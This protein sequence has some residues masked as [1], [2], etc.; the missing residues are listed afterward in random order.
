MS[1]Q[2]YDETTLGSLVLNV[3]TQQQ[4]DDIQE[5]N[6]DELYLIKDVPEDKGIYYIEGNVN[7][8]AGQW[9]GTHNSIK[10]YYP[11]LVIAYKIG[12]K[13][14]STATELEIN[15]LGKIPVVKNQ[16]TNISTTYGVNSVVILIYTVDKGEGYW[17][18][19]D[20]STNFVTQ[21]YTKN[22]SIYPLLFKYDAGTTN[23][24]D[25][26]TSTQYSNSIYVNPSSGTIT[27]A[28]FN[29]PAT[30]ATNDSQG[31][32]ITE[33]Y[34]KQTNPTGTGTFAL[35]GNKAIGTNS[36]A[37]GK[38]TT[39][40]GD[41]SHAEGT[42]INFPPDNIMDETKENIYSN[43][44]EQ[45]EL[46]G[47]YSLAYGVGS[48]V[49]G[50]NCLALGDQSHAEGGRTVAFEECSHAE[51]FAVEAKG[52]YSHAEGIS[53]IATAEGSHVE[54]R[55]NIIDNDKKYL[56]IV[57]NGTDVKKSNAF[58]LDQ[59][60]NAWFAGDIYIGSASGTNKDDGSKKVATEEFVLSSIG[61]NE[62]LATKQYVDNLIGA[63]LDGAS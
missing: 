40:K 45:G 33:T 21:K 22:N 34:M 10:E 7:G 38:Q 48:H 57:G 25:T 60:G 24:G 27:A 26:T 12:T 3:L 52:R 4:F 47:L 1:S 49:E 18:T 6:A 31:N 32:V 28:S 2:K 36:H 54:G 42:S 46:N 11:G 58:T 41:Y 39:A 20:Y 29:G 43:W 53:T 17:K 16:S 9:T 62:E 44:I 50:R 23:T 61:T 37:E 55:H 59:Q 13:G 15:G 19:A 14:S 51:G 56:H 35:N 30:S 63:I 5:K 8:T